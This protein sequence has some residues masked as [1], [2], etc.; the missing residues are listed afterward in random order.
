MA[1]NP[2]ASVCAAKGDRK[3]V[4]AVMGRVFCLFPPLTPQEKGKLT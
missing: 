4:L 1:T 2:V 3:V